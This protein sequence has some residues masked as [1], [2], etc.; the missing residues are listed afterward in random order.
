[1]TAS[2]EVCVVAYRNEDTIGALVESLRH[3]PEAS[4]ALHD[5]GPDAAT[6][7][8]AAQAAAS[9]GIAFRG[10][11]C[12]AGNC[13]FGAGCNALAATSSATELLLLNPDAAVVAWPDGLSAR[14]RIVGALV[15]GPDGTPSHIWGTSRRLRDEALLRWARRTPRRPVGAGYVSGAAMLVGRDTFSSLGGFDEDYFMY[16]EDIDLCTRAVAAGIPV[17]LEPEWV[18]VHEGGHSVGRSVESL[19]RAFMTSYESGRRFHGKSG[20]VRG[21]DALVLA[22]STARAVAFRTARTRRPD[23]SANAAVARAAVRR[24]L[25]RDG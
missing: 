19:T 22:D 3:V 5:N 14:G 9:A 18:V 6:L 8:V 20:H 7:P 4:L 12:N 13:G 17:V 21:Y 23:A 2:V 15:Q 24:L 16:Y 10:E 1:M 25:G 11:A